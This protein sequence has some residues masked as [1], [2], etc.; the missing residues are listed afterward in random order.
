[1]G[2]TSKMCEPP[3]MLLRFLGLGGRLGVF[4]RLHEFYLHRGSANL[5]SLDSSPSISKEHRA[6]SDGETLVMKRVFQATVMATL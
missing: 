2:V 1:M 4:W 5:L 6:R 3:G